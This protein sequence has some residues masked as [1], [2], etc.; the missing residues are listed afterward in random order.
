MEQ[1]YKAHWCKLLIIMSVI[2][3]LILMLPSALYWVDPEP[4]LLFAAPL[5]LLIGIGAALF[6]IRG[7]TVTRD[8]LHI[9]R[10]FWKTRIPL[11]NLKSAQ[12][13]PEAFRKCIRTCGNGGLFSFSGF[14]YSKSVGHF[15]ALV[16]DL[17]NPVVLRFEKRTLVISPSEPEAFLQNIRAF[18]Q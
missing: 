12:I 13:N 4:S 9:Q 17:A 5:C 6:T 2:A 7:Y 1:H 15:R 14:Y 18:I 8:E 3:S 10:L 16:T 11:K